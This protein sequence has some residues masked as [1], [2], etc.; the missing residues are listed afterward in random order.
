MNIGYQGGGSAGEFSPSA[1]TGLLR[2][3]I[4]VAPVKAVKPIFLTASFLD[5]L[6]DCSLS[7]LFFFM[8]IGLQ[9]LS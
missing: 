1:L 5:I 2:R 4:M 9:A 6:F 7:V 8:P 3:N